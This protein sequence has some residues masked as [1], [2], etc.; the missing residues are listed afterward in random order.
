[1]EKIGKVYG[2]TRLFSNEIEF[3]YSKKYYGTQ[4]DLKYSTVM[5]YQFY[6]Y[7]GGTFR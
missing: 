7:M 4:V 3:G 5:F 1:M 2:H 6:L